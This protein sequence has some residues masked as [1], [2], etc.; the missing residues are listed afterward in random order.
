MLKGSNANGL[1]PDF[2]QRGQAGLYLIFI[3]DNARS[4]S[5]VTHGIGRC[6]ANNI[7]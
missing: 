5:G 7:F 2:F 3:I 4:E 1:G 6:A